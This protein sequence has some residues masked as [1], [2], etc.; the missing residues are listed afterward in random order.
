VCL[1]GG[2]RPA[3]R[4]ERGAPSSTTTPPTTRSCAP[5]KRSSC[6]VAIFRARHCPSRPTTGPSA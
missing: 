3:S 6:D 4:F 1:R 2:V 5:G